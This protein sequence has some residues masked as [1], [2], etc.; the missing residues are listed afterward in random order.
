VVAKKEKR[1]KKKEKIWDTA[2]N[3]THF[4]LPKL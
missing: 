4:T 1:K 2:L 3:P